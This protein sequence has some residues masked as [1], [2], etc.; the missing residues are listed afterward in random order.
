MLKKSDTWII[1]TRSEAI[2]ATRTQYWTGK[3]CA[4]GHESKRYTSSGICCKCNY[5]NVI[6]YQNRKI[7]ELRGI[8]GPMVRVSFMIPRSQEQALRDYAAL[9]VGIAPAV[10]TRHPA[11]GGGTL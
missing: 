3:T 10:I 6:E 4:R 5:E 2:A 9:L 1:E 8:E 11:L 7:N